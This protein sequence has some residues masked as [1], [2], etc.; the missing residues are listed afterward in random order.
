MASTTTS[1]HTSTLVRP[2]ESAKEQYQVHPLYISEFA[3]EIYAVLILA[4]L[5]RR[6]WVLYGIALVILSHI[7]DIL[8]AWFRHVKGAREIRTFKSWLIW[9]TRIGLDFATNAVEGDFV[10]VL[11]AGSLNFWNLIG[12]RLTT[13]WFDNIA[14]KG[15]AK[16]LRQAKENLEQLTKSYNNFAGKES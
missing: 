4:V 1:K 2:L 6:F 12:K 3:M 5:I 9:W 15:R 16:V 11:V 13:N 8:L 14:T 10:H 7:A